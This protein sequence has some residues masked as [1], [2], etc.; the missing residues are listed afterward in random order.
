M[1]QPKSLYSH[2]KTVVRK[3]FIKNFDRLYEILPRTIVQELLREWFLCEEELSL[4]DEDNDDLWDTIDNT[5]IFHQFRIEE[6]SPNVF[7]AICALS[8]NE[9]NKRDTFTFLYETNHISC[10]YY[11]RKNCITNC[12]INICERCFLTNGNLIQNENIIYLRI[13][14]HEVVKYDSLYKDI[15]KDKQNWCGICM[16]EPLFNIIHSNE[17]NSQFHHSGYSY[18]IDENDERVYF[19]DSDIDN[20]IMME[21]EVINPQ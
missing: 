5:T 20:D 8:E 19:S 1:F 13:N 14:K 4:S 11:L 16:I 6:G 3:N 21:C 18:Y 15:L 17:C 10:T 9:Y 2:A 7:V 12:S